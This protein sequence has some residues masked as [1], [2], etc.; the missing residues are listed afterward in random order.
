MWPPCASTIEH[1]VEGFDQ[2]A[3]LGWCGARWPIPSLDVP[4]YLGIWYEVAKYPNRFLRKCA[5]DT[6]AIYSQRW[7]SRTA[8]A[9]G[10]GWRD[11]G[12]QSSQG[13][14]AAISSATRA[15]NLSNSDSSASS[16]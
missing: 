10:G 3:Q 1:A 7:R 8:G 2:F 11:G 4:R 16:P 9:G 14:S 15:S 6:R 13:L 12:R 5:S